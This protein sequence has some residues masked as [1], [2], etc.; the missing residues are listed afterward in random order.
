[1]STRKKVDMPLGR[2]YGEMVAD[3]VRENPEYARELL[4]RAL[5]LLL[6]GDTSTAKIMFRDLVNGTQGFVALARETGLN[7][8]SLHRMLGANG[9]PRMENLILIAQALKKALGV[10]TRVEASRSTG[11]RAS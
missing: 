1:M 4:G 2:E 11:R 5:T 10:E 6:D 3:D 8:K 7:D 9:N